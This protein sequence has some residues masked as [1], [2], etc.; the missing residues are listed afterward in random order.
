[1]NKQDSSNN[2]SSSLKNIPN[3]GC[4]LILDFN[5]VDASV[6][7]MNDYPTMHEFLTNVIIT[8]G[9]TIEGH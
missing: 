7:D 5:D 4:H 9:G 2:L 8:S 1:M 6:F 3:M